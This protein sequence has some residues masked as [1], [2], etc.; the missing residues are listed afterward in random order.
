MAVFWDMIKTAI[1]WIV[2]FRIIVIPQYEDFVSNNSSSRYALLTTIVAYH[3]YEWAH[4][5]KFTVGHFK[6]T[7]P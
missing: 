3:M 7:Y 6:S 5:K 4:R 2:G 1:S